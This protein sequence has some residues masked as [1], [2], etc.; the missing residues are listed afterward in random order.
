MLPLGGVRCYLEIFVHKF[1]C[2]DCGSCTWVDLPFATGKFPMT[3]TFVTYVLSLVKIA[4]VQS[5][6]RFLDLQWKTVKNLHKDYL[7][8]KYKTISYKKLVYLSMDEFSIRK[9]H[10]YMTVFLDLGSGRIIHAVRGRSVEDIKPFLEKLSKKACQLRAVAMDMSRSYI[11]SVQKYLPHVA[12]IFDRFHVVKQLNEAVDETRKQERAK[13]EAEGLN[14]G[15]GD[16]FLFLRNFRDL[17]EDERGRLQKLFEINAVL[18]RAHFIKE[19]FL[20][21]WEEKSKQAAAQFLVRWI[22]EAVKSGIKA[23]AQAAFTI[24]AHYEGL[25]NYF[26][27]HISNGPLEGTNNKIKV[28]KRTGYG[29]RDDEYFILL[30][31]DL[32][33]KDSQLVG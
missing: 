26:D 22:Y 30:L 16:R 29:Y 6:A 2:R 31:Y 5:T 17:S 23:I 32:H 24:L 19:Q 20:R 14:V 18:A 9:G 8:E 27:H 33:E 11:S 10:S 7:K 3:K 21:F 25:L 13:Y 4:T 15:K 12:I 1:K 28:L